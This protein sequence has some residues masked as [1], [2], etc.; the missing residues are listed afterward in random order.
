MRERFYKHNRVTRSLRFCTF[1]CESLSLWPS[2]AVTLV[3]LSRYQNCSSPPRAWALSSRIRAWT[4][5][6]SLQARLAR[7]SKRLDTAFWSLSTWTQTCSIRNVSNYKRSNQTQF[8]TWRNSGPECKLSDVSFCCFNSIKDY[9]KTPFNWFL[10]DLIFYFWSG[11][12]Y[13]P[14]WDPRASKV[15]HSC[16]HITFSV[17]QFSNHIMVT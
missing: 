5:F 6:C 4:W 13:G 14:A 11:W 12:I 3:R 15:T 16:N 10:S 1:A 8:G 17:I 9:I 7:W 2:T